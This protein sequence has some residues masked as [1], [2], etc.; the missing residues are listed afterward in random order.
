MISNAHVA[1]I[2]ARMQLKSLRWDPKSE[3]FTGAYAGEANRF[4]S[5][6]NHDGWKL[7]AF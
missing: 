6:E 7:A 4:L 1:N 5:V 2:C 3:M